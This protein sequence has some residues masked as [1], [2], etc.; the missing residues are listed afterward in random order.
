M[1]D[2]VDAEIEQ[3]RGFEIVV[4]DDP[5]EF[6]LL[7]M[8]GYSYIVHGMGTFTNIILDVGLNEAIKITYIAPDPKNQGFQETVNTMLSTLEFE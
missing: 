3:E 5:E 1:K 2:F 7:E 8:T 4:V 6:V